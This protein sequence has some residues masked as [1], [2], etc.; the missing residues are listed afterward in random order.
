MT[1]PI[2]EPQEHTQTKQ[3]PP[4]HVLIENDDEHSMDF[5]VMVLRKVF[6][7]DDTK[8]HVL[9]Q[10]AHEG[11][12]AIVW[13]GSKEVAEWKLEQ[14]GTFRENHWRDGRDIGPLRCRIEPAT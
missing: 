1:T 3:L 2:A 4:Y 5:V 7:Y 9:M 14:I 11:G 12:E 8:A 13:T 10:A 6:G